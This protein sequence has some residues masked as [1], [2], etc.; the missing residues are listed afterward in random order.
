MSQG[1]PGRAG[2]TTL[3]VTLAAFFAFVGLLMV[4]A[5][6]GFGLA[7]G[8]CVPGARSVHGMT[9]MVGGGEMNSRLCASHIPAGLWPWPVVSVVVG[10]AVGGVFG[11][12]LIHIFRSGIGRL[13]RVG[14]APG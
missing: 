2:R 10:A 7:I 6:T 5:I 1:W 8:H 4:M 3:I 13:R 9:P 14:I 12:G 11:A